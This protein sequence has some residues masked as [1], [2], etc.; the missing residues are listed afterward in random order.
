MSV[1]PHPRFSGWR[2]CGF[3]ALTQALAI[4]FTLGAVGLFFGPLADEFGMTATHFGL[5]VSGFSLV[6]NLSMPVIG[7]F[8]D[9][10]SIRGVMALGALVLALNLLGI[11]FATALWQVGL[12]FSV[13]CAVGM[14]M[15]GPMA[16]STAMANW[17]DRLRGRAL[18]LANAGAPAGPLVIVPIAGLVVVE[19]G[20]RSTV[21]GFAAAALLVAAPVAWL[22]MIDRPG[23]VG[24]HPDGDADHAA[25]TPGA[26]A[27]EGADWDVASILGSRDF[28]LMALAAAPFGAQ[29]I[30]LAANSIPYLAHHGASPEA[31]AVA[32]VP[33]SIGAVLGPLLFGA[34]ADKIHPRKLFIGLC[35]LICLV[36]GG[37][38]TG[39]GYAISLVLLAFCGLVGGSMMPV[40]GALIGRLFG[41][42]AFGQ[43]MGLGALVGLPVITIA[44]VA[45]GAAFDR[46]GDFAVGLGGLIAS[47]IASIALFAL[48]SSG[49]ARRSAQRAPA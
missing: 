46:S 22:G 38:M 47:L 17:F 25:V 30:V 27:E 6:M 41:V 8:L 45:F 31:A 21:I 35:A 4:G 42:N 13:G 32:P 29:G 48:V 49:E 24:Q 9:G 5:G 20:W 33:L 1:A 23:D 15:L 39:P 14:A 16:S 12:L 7:R 43:V 28:W 10:G 36:F 40:Y 3:S 34:L 18:G 44:P 37:L 11:A 19:L 26:P 2:V